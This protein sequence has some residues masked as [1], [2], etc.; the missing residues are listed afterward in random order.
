SMGL[1]TGIIGALL[2]IAFMIG[3]YGRWGL[4]A[5]T[6]L[7]VNIG[8]AFGVLSLL[9]ATLTLP[10][11]AGFILSIGM[12]VD[13]NILINERIREEPRRRSRCRFPSSLPNHPRFQ[14][15]LTDRDQSAVFI[16]QR[17]CAWICSDHGSGT[18]HLHVYGNL[19]HSLDH[20]MASQSFRSRSTGNFRH[21]STGPYQQ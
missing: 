6:G 15:Y 17:A 14:H 18:D 16:W 10:G 12:A 19:G 5:C 7:A 1:S 9:G 21:Q 20:G 2:V 4:I 3:I 13:A 8:L 11:I